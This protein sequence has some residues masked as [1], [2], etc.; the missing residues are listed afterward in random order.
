[1]FSS[2]L[3]PFPL[4]ALRCSEP[5]SSF[6]STQQSLLPHPQPSFLVSS[7]SHLWSYSPPPLRSQS[8]HF[9]SLAYPCSGTVCASLSR[10]VIRGPGY[11]CCTSG[12]RQG[13]E[14]E[15]GSPAGRQTVPQSGE[16]RWCLESHC[17]ALR[18]QESKSW[19]A[20]SLQHV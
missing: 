1:M 13:A 15:M 20:L 5:C 6:F 2:Y 8:F 18:G 16:H 9:Q 17:H 19:K 7:F 11:L 10:I 12:C 4:L 3:L 14:G